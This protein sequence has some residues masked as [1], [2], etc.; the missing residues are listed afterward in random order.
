MEIGRRHLYN[1]LQNDIASRN[2][3][4][5]DGTDPLEQCAHAFVASN[6]N[7]IIPPRSTDTNHLVLV[8]SSK[9]IRY[10]T[11]HVP[12]RTHDDDLHH[13]SFLNS[14]SNVTILP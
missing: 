12:S 8:I 7:L 4:G 9:L 2:N 13:H 14:D 3:D 6:V 1:R 5:V 10:G 11:T